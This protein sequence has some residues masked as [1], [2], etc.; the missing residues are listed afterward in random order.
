MDFLRSPQFRKIVGISIFFLDLRKAKKK[1]DKKDSL[2]SISVA[3]TVLN[4]FKFSNL[5]FIVV[6]GY[7]KEVVKLYHDLFNM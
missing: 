7:L 5:F 6:L 2:T 4:P 3:R 1:V